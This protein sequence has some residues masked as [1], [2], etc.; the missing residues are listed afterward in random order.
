MIHVVNL[1][2]AIIL[3]KES[4]AGKLVS[5]NNKDDSPDRLIKVEL[6]VCTLC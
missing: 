3:N 4:V 2:W 6:K 5:C 1:V